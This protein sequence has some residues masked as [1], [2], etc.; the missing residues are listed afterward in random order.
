MWRS[1]QTFILAQRTP[2]VARLKL[3]NLF[4]RKQERDLDV[5]VHDSPHDS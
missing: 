3:A 1:W 2:E 5:S 4:L